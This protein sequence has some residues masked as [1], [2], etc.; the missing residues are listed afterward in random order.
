MDKV[1]GKNHFCRPEELPEDMAVKDYI[2]TFA[3]LLKLTGREKRD[4]LDSPAISPISQQIIGKL[5]QAGK[6][7]VLTGLMR[8]KKDRVFLVNDIDK[9]LSHIYSIQ[10][11]ERIDELTANGL[12]VIF[13]TS[14]VTSKDVKPNT[15]FEKSSIWTYM[16]EGNK[17]MIEM[18]QQIEKEQGETS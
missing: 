11:K 7:E 2:T 4:L 3:N 10:L 1:P 12:T 15:F 16:V 17:K 9:D 8:I 18:R 13:L 5:S 14:Y 6:F